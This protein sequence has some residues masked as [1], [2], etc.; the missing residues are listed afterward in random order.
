MA[1]RPNVELTTV[2]AAAL[3]VEVAAAAALL[4]KVTLGVVVAEVLEAVEVAFST[5][6]WGEFASVDEEDD[7]MEDEKE[8]VTLEEEEDEDELVLEMVVLDELELDDDW[9]LELDDDDDVVDTWAELVV[10]VEVDDGVG[11]GVGV[12]EVDEAALEEDLELLLDP[13]SE[14][15]ALKTTMLAELPLGTVTTQKSPPPAPV[16]DN[17]DVT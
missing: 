15:P 1:L 17:E 10:E 6:T 9:L 7:E 14:L 16:A 4:A 11:V 8:V 12:A 2:L 13:P 3:F 5:K